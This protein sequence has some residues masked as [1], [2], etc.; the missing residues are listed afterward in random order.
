MRLPK[1]ILDKFY[2]KT[3]KILE[4]LLS[5]QKSMQSDLIWLI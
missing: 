1:N 5:L 2:L 4:K 3:I